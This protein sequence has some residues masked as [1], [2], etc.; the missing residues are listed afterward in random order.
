MVTATVHQSHI[1]QATNEEGGEQ[2]GVSVKGYVIMNIT[3]AGY[4]RVLCVVVWLGCVCEC[5]VCT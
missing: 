3:M 4:V 1:T 5:C 2:Q